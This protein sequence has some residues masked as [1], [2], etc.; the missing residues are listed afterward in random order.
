MLSIVCCFS[1]IL[2]KYTGATFCCTSSL[3]DMGS[4]LLPRTKI[5][6]INF[7]PTLSVKKYGKK[8]ETCG[9]HYLIVINVGKCHEIINVR[10]LKVNP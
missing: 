10:I 5:L 6:N 3:T 1:T 2:L 7:M 9:V 4:Q 8:Y